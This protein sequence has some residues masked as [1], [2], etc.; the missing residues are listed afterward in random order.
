MH[1][2]Y[3]SNRNVRTQLVVYGATYYS[4]MPVVLWFGM[5]HLISCK[6]CEVANPRLSHL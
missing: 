1:V 4:L 5:K 6:E 3:K 2:L